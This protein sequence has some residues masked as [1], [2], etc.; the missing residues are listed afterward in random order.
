MHEPVESHAPVTPTT[1]G[2]DQRPADGHSRRQFLRRFGLL[3]G[4][5]IATPWAY[6]L[7]SLAPAAAAAPGDDYRALV[8]VFLYGG[9]DHWDTFVPDDADGHGAYAAA[10]PGLAHGRGD[11]LG[12]DPIG[13]FTGAGSIG[14]APQLSRLHRLFND[15]D[16][17]VVANV[18][19][20]L[21]PTSKQDYSAVAKRPPQLFSH[22]DQQSFWQSGSPE[23]ATSGWGG[24]IADALLAGNGDASLFTSISASGNA[25]M[26]SGVD[27]LQYQVSSR[28]VTTLRTDLLGS[29]S[30][31]SGLRAVMN[32]SRGGL[33]PSAYT[34]TTR[35]ALQ[36]ADDLSDALDAAT[37][38]LDLGD[39]FAREN[40]PAPAANLLG[41]LEVVAR[42]I[43]AGR[44]ALGLRRQV[45]F[46]GLGGFDNHSRLVEDHRP[47]LESL[48]IG[49]SGFHGAM[50]AVGAGDAVTTFTASDF[51]RSLV[52]NGDGTD[53]GWGAHH[54]VVGGAVAGNRVVGAL[55]VVADDG[56]DDVGRGRLLPSTSV[57]QYSASLARWLGATEAD[58]RLVAPTIDA[59]P[60][61]D[62]NLFT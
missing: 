9:N 10:R 13:G 58:V 29:D 37:N 7:A 40:T 38:G 25:V 61:T 59:F 60:Q 28:G 19:T 39:F 22:N 17:A 41:Q 16:A 6:Q 44:D 35:R 34:A 23:G 31:N 45:F 43:L 49:L 32:Q 52:S 3:A 36:A 50:Q 24:R 20:L 2:A 11:V 15:G 27:A 21:G 53:H 51:G 18:G 26:M 47:L 4:A 5:G 46:V 55:P 62:L 54:L 33:F 56:P 14:F 12:V 57:D 42:L 8:C 1:D 48:D 30:L